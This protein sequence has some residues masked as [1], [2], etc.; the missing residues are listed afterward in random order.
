MEEVRKKHFESPPQPISSGGIVP[1]AKNSPVVKLVSRT[2]SVVEMSV[3]LHSLMMGVP[4]GY[5]CNAEQQAI[6]IAKVAGCEC[7]QWYSRPMLLCV[8]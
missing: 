1:G 7:Q 4:I 5:Y 2:N 3:D 6:D 8:Q